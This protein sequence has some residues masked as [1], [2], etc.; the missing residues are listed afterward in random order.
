MTERIVC[1]SDRLLFYCLLPNLFSFFALCKLMR[2][3]GQSIVC[4][5]FFVHQ[6]SDMLGTH[7]H[8]HQPMLLAT[9]MAV[10]SRLV[11]FCG[12]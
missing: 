1:E 11:S 7:T 12:D 10:P 4:L 9:K 3:P 8:T 5:S 2:Q 6:L